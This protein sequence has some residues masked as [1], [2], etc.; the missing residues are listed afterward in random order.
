MLVSFY[1]LFEMPS[2]QRESPYLLNQK[3]QEI[4]SLPASLEDQVTINEPMCSQAVHNFA[5]QLG[6]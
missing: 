4:L 5:K 1:P 2:A 6:L 3:L